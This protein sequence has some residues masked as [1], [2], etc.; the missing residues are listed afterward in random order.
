MEALLV[1]VFV[2]VGALIVGN[3][4]TR[5]WDRAR[6]LIVL[7]NFDIVTKN[8][9]RTGCDRDL[10]ELTKQS[11]VMGIITEGEVYYGEIENAY[12]LSKSDLESMDNIETWVSDS[13]TALKQSESIQDK[14]EAIK[15]IFRW[16]GLKEFVEFMFYR[17]LVSDL[18]LTVPDDT[19]PQLNAV[20]SEEDDG[21]IIVVFHDS[22]G[23][24]GG[25]FSKDKWKEE[26]IQPLI[27]AIQLLDTEFLVKVLERIPDIAIRQREICRKILEKTTPIR[28]NHSLWVA[29]CTMVN[30]GN[31]PLIIWPEAHL[32]L[33]EE[34]GGKELRVPCY[35]ALQKEDNPGDANDFSGPT[36]LS[37]GDEMKLWVITKETKQHMTDGNLVNAYFKDKSANGRVRLIVTQRGL[38]YKTSC[39]ST[40]F[41]FAGED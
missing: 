2:A 32:L 31:S 8:K 25:S 26:A 7:S 14:M 40:S 17:S 37:P 29:K 10:H 38:P 16:G 36:V 34:K 28:E 27:R 39:K 9:D 18:E 33:K 20:P 22:L 41:L 11:F 12:C 6:P 23:H 24:L 21:S 3:L 1:N 4:L 13:K 5:W 19:E 30:Y 15:S 35:L